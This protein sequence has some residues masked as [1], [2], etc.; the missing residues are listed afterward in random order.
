MRCARFSIIEGN[1][2]DAKTK[3]RY[4]ENELENLKLQRKSLNAF[5]TET[6]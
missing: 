3:E 4:M 6:I 5:A 1:F 2:D